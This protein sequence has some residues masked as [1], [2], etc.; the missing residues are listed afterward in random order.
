[1]AGGSDNK[2]ER[3]TSRKLT[4]AREKGQIARSKEIPLAGVLL[5]MLGVLYYSGRSLVNAFEFEMQDKF[6]FRIPAD[7]SMSYVSGM[8]TDISARLAGIVG[9]ILLAAVAF[10]VTANVIQG[11]FVFSWEAM[12][13]HFEKLSPKNGMGRLLSKNGLV[14][15]AKSLLLLII[16]SSISY[17]V[18]SKHLELYPRMVL[19]DIRQVIYW[20]TSISFDVFLRSAAFLAVLSLADYGFQRYRFLEQLKMTKQEVKDEFK[21]MEG[22][23]LIRGRIRRLQRE[24]ARKRMMTDVPTADVVITNPTHYAVALS[25]KLD[26]MEAPQVVAKGVGILALKI[27]ELAQQ[28]NVPIVENKP[29][30]QTLY[31]TVEI[32]QFIPAELYRAVAE[33]LAYIFKAKN[34]WKR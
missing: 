28:H 30:A 34:A 13:L 20:I 29:L 32:G 27:R 25:Y 18:V 3:P 22:D 23:P 8:M 4:K 26:E 16:I 2:T 11:G 15:L 14:E 7:F 10:A 31:K 1:M 21:D 12:G 33:I 17:S 24:M 19:M 9:P 5:G 6:R